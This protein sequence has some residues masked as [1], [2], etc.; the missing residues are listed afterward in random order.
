VFFIIIHAVFKKQNTVLTQTH[1]FCFKIGGGRHLD[2]FS[3][4]LFR[5]PVTLVL[6]ISISTPNLVQIGREVEEILS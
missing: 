3:K 1:H 2:F 4:V 5:T 6:A